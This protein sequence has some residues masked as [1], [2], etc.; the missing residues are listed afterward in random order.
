VTTNF[1]G[2]EQEL[3]SLHA[4]LREALDGGRTIGFVSGEAGA[5]KTTLIREFARQ[6]QEQLPGLVFA[7]GDCD[8]QARAGDPY[9]PFREICSFLTGNSEPPSTPTEQDT[10]N[11]RRVQTLLQGTG[12]VAAHYA[13]ALI[14]MLVPGGKLITRTGSFLGDRLGWSRRLD[15]LLGRE[16]RK[17]PG[18]DLDQAQM[19]EQFTQYISALSDQHPLLIVLDDLQWADSATLGLFFHLAR[20]LSEKKVLILGTYR[21][22]DLTPE[23]DGSRH[24]LLKL[25]YEL[26]RMF[27]PIVIDLDESRSRRGRDLVDQLL[28]REPNRLGDDFRDALFKRTGGSALFTVELLST[29]KDRGVLVRDDEKGWIQAADLDWSQVPPRVEGIIS[30]R[31]NRL[32]AASLEL[33]RA[34]ATEGEE[35]TAEVAACAAGW[36]PR[37]AIRHLSETLGRQEQLVRAL[38]VS[39]TQGGRA[40]R[41]RFGHTLFRQQLMTSLDAAERCYLHETIANCLT[42][43]YGKTDG[44]EQQL[45]SHLLEARLEQQA[46]PYLVAAAESALEGFANREALRALERA[47]DIIEAG[48]AT[49]LD[50]HEIPRLYRRLAEVRLLLGRP[51]AALEAVREGL[52]RLAEDGLAERVRLLCLEGNAW[53]LQNEER[54]ALN[55]YELASRLCA[56]DGK[57]PADLRKAWIDT[58]IGQMWAHYFAG[59]TESLEQVIARFQP[60][61]ESFGSKEQQATLLHGRLLARMR[62]RRF[63]LVGD[64]EAIRL[65]AQL[66]ESSEASGRLKMTNDAAF[67]N[68]LVN[69]LAENWEHSRR[70][71]D[72]SLQLSEKIGD[73]PGHARA[74]AYLTVLERRV[75]NRDRAIEH[76]RKLKEA[77]ESSQQAAYLSVAL[78]QSGWWAAQEGDFDTA[79]ADCSEAVRLWE[80]RPVS[81]PLQWLAY[82]PLARIGLE[83]QRTDRLRD[84]F[85]ML[86][87]EDQQPMPRTIDSHITETVRLI[88]HRDTSKAFASAASAL[89]AAQEAGYL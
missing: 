30:E 35:F 66:A 71:L 89:Q 56:P 16:G 25:Q 50:P 79:E 4:W 8:G 42:R 81:Y 39:G 51:D 26:S 75:G 46:L 10:E 78:A 12:R 28:D 76:A 44:L 32:S 38:G 80:E 58:G 15:R 36:E 19:Y 73:A 5:G 69:L 62:R 61:S 85:C 54:K 74:L 31:L 21:P 11:Y 64:A 68:G 20:R 45:A 57:V 37:D 1:V 49:T 48:G 27:G 77:V 84:A 23:D 13:P 59:D 33:L 2:R 18:V 70:H 24:E 87:R 67:V 52:D 86:T 40:S 3:G 7:F 47:L 22:H 72:R 43:V 9:L 53:R 63:L 14:E 41:Y 17:K 55:A 34:A 82:W 88:D 60:V 83:T 29:L 6:A 65:T